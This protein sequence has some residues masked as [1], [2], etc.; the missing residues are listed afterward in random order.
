MEQLQEN[1][2]CSVRKDGEEK[3]KLGKNE[4]Q[5]K[6]KKIKKKE[7]SLQVWNVS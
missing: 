2:H 3:E 6:K 7:V 5:N 4:Q 1:A